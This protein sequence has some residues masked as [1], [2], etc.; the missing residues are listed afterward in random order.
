MWQAE[1]AWRDALRATTIADLFTEVVTTVPHDVL[2]KG[3]E[4]IQDVQ[5]RRR[6][7]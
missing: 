3:A 5:I 1:E 2:E 7:R 6:S 4:W